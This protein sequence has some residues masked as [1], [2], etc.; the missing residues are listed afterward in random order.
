MD[1]C[2]YYVARKYHPEGPA[3]RRSRSTAR[4]TPRTGWRA[5]TTCRW[6]RACTASSTSRCS[7][8]GA[9]ELGPFRI[10]T[11]L[12]VH[13]IDAYGLRIEQAGKVLTYSGDTGI[14]DGL[15]RLAKDSDLFLC[16][17]SFHDGRDD[18]PEIH[19]NGREAAEHAARAGAAP[20]RADPHPAVE[21]PGRARSARPPASSTARSSWPARRRLHALRLTLGSRD[22]STRE[23]RERP[24][25]S[26]HHHPAVARP[27]RGLGARRVRQDPRALRRLVTEGVP[28]WR[29]GSGLGWVTAEYAMLPARHA[30]PRRPRVGQ[31]QASAG[32]RTRSPG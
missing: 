1:L 19:L 20:A 26:R 7:R 2:G 14:C 16:E 32:A 18:A 17:A 28:R 10:T 4:P 25:P 22:A 31:G 12:L 6:I 30:H 3:S 29:K 9:F 11:D 24:A 15:V 13:P 8:R 27:R 23:P 5:P 21:R